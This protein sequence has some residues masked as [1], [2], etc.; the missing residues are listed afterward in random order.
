MTTKT[1]SEF[2]E[3]MKRVSLGAGSK[4]FETVVADILKG[5]ALGELTPRR[6]PRRSNG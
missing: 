6:K 3:R 2:V 5:L 4:E 1:Q